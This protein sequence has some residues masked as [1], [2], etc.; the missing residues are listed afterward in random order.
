MSNVHVGSTEPVFAAP[1]SIRRSFHG[2]AVYLSSFVMLGCATLL[3]GPSLATFRERTG[4]SKGSIGILL[5]FGAIGYLFGSMLG[6]SLL[7]RVKVHRIMALGLVTMA[8]SLAGVA[9]S[10]TFLL[11]KVTQAVLGFGAALVDTTGNT[12]VLWSFKDGPVMNA[13]HSCFAIGGTFAPGL[14]ALS[15]SLSGDLRWGYCIV[16]AIV[17]AGAFAVLRRPSPTS[18]HDAGPNERKPI[19]VQLLVVGMLFYF[20]YV[21]VEVGFISWINDYAVARGLSANKEATFLNT[22]FLVAF[23]FGRVV[24]VP[25][26]SRLK[27]KQVLSVDI[28]ACILGLMI[29]LIGGSSRPALWAGTVIFGLGTASMFAT[30]LLLMEPYIPSTGAVTSSFLIAASLGSMLV[31]WLIGKRFDSVGAQAMPSTVL[32][33]V[34]A[35]GFVVAT[36]VGLARSE[37][38]VS[39]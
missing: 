30:M 15:I 36:F 1:V 27:P 6:G 23:T 32:V 35:C 37:L 5:T 2:S 14:V 39:D 13:L 8:V 19:R 34:L 7:D 9:F 26:S 3:V 31:P 10:N 22:A 4:L 38:A 18:P 17:A 33:G 25:I 12:V 24:G 21:G 20:L 28:A 29:L 16:A 11:L